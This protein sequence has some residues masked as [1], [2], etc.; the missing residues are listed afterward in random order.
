MEGPDAV[1]T[2]SYGGVSGLN[3]ISLNWL[4]WASASRAVMSSLMAG[5]VS[6]KMFFTENVLLALNRRLSFSLQFFC[7]TNCVSVS[8]TFFPVECASGGVV[9]G[10]VKVKQDR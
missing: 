7:L 1:S 3:G 9:K 2:I 8:D 4:W 10:V 6:L 5:I